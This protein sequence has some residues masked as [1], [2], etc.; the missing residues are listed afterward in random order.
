[1]IAKDVEEGLPLINDAIYSVPKYHFNKRAANAFAA[2][3]YLYY[4]KWDEAIAC[5]TAALSETPASTLRNYEELLQYPMN[6]GSTQNTA[7]TYYIGTE[8]PC[9]YLLAT[10]YS[11]SGTYFGGYNTGLQYNHGQYIAKNEGI[12]A[13]N[14]PFAPIP[15]NAGL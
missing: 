4:Q 10:A 13:T 1:M 9:N 12:S 2:R 8:L 14:M 7:A 11:Q 6:N 3:F 15:G 5:A